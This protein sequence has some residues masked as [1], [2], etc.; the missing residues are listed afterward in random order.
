MPPVFRHG[1]EVVL[2]DRS[3]PVI[4]SSSSLLDALRAIDVFF[5]RGYVHVNGSWTTPRHS[6]GFRGPVKNHVIHEVPLPRSL[7]HDDLLPRVKELLDL[8]DADRRQRHLV[9]A[10]GTLEIL[11]EG[12]Q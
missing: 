2:S 1:T 7:M 4:G 5:D 6:P 9:Q 11:V 3:P 8:P 12:R 10:T